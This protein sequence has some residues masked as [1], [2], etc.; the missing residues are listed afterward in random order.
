MNSLFRLPGA[1]PREL[2]PYQE[3]AIELLRESL[4]TG[5]K[6]PVLQLPTGTGKTLIAAEIIRWALAKGHRVIFTV[7]RISLIE[8]TVRDFEKHGVDAIGVIQGQHFR[9]DSSAPVQIASAQTL[10]RRDFSSS[11][12]DWD[13]QRFPRAGLVIIDEAHLQFKKITDWIASPDWAAVPFVGLTATPWARGMGK[14]Y[15]D[16]VKFTSIAEMIAEGFLT[17]FRVFAPPAPD[18]SKVR[19]ASTGDYR[20]DDLSDACDQKE[21]VADVVQTWFERGENRPTLCYGVDR[22]HAQHLQER[23]VEA[24][25]ATE[26][27]DCDTPMFEREEIFDRFRAS[28]TK[29]ICNVATL[30]TGLDLDVRCIIDARPTK[31]RIRF[32]QTIGRGLR[33][34]EGKDHLIVLDHAGNTQ[35]L[36]LVTQIDFPELDDGTVLGRNMDKGKQERAPRIKLCPE[37]RHVLPSF[38]CPPNCPACGAKLFAAT[39]VVEKPGELIEFGSDKR[40]RELTKLLKR[41]EALWHGALARIAKQKGYSQGWVSHQFR[42]RFGYWPTARWPKECEPTVE[43]KNYVRSRQIA[44]AKA[45][46]K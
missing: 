28:E 30:D 37:C 43:I 39:A 7:P 27:I 45:R 4:R 25:V 6:R 34:A 32:V 12:D 9:T 19:T 31:S 26:Y 33:P 22:A 1:E 44:Y 11:H 41:D 24:G 23:F 40:G 46:G 29:L 35:R 13:K 38:Q 21:I 36:G 3:R 17:P 14:S 18:L 5:H 42:S 16:L 8:Q 10:V 20:D 2:R 15:D